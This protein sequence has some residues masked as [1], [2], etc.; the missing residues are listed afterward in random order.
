MR[1]GAGPPRETEPPTRAGPVGI[2][3]VLERQRRRGPSGPVHLPSSYPEHDIASSD[4]ALLL[5]AADERPKLWPGNRSL[6]EKT[7][8]HTQLDLPVPK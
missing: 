1:H 3:R 6:A 8:G 2:E 5:A 4:G 7:S